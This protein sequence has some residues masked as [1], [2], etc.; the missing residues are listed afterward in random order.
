MT[1]LGRERYRGGAGERGGCLCVCVSGSCM[2]RAER[3]GERGCL[4]LY[5]SPAAAGG[6]SADLGAGGIVIDPQVGWWE[7]G[8][9][10]EASRVGGQF[11]NR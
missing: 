2:E 8:A 9:G 5:L 3:E 10:P 1:T 4:W 11:A 6:S 7:A